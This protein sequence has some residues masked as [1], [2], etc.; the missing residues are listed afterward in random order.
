[1]STIAIEQLYLGF[2]GRPATYAEL[3]SWTLAQRNHGPLDLRTVL[4]QS[5]DYQAALAKGNDYL[6]DSVYQNL[7]GHAADASGRAYWSGLLADGKISA[8]AL[9]ETLAASARGDDA[10]ALRDRIAGAESFSAALDLRSEVASIPENNP[11]PGLGKAWMQGITDL[12]SLDT[13]FHNLFET[14]TGGVA[15]LIPIP[16]YGHMSSKAGAGLV[17]E[18]YVGFFGRP[19]D[20]T[21]VAYWEDYLGNGGSVDALRDAFAK[22]QEFGQAVMLTDNAHLVDGLYINMFGRHGEPGGLSYWSG[23]LDTGKATVPTVIEAI[24]AGAVGTDAEALRAKIVAAT[25]YTAVQA[26]GAVQTLVPADPAVSKA[27]LA[28]VTDDASLNLALDTVVHGGPIVTTGPVA[29]VGQPPEPAYLLI[30]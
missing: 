30:G 8:A 5:S 29:A 2:L 21:G 19:G 24:A 23:L 27:W 11:E 6:V 12:N 15:A 28:G 14:V 25:A 13:A 16:P 7:F 22:S 3:Q 17:E 4:F 9:P 1:M 20:A 18:L 26:L 10:T